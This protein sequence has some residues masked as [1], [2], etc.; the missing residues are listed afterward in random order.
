[1]SKSKSATFRCPDE[2]WEKMEPLIPVRANTHR[3]G[4]GRPRVPDRQCMDGIFFVL[5]TGCA[6]KAL[7]E[8]KICSASTAHARFEEWV[9]AGVFLEFWKAG[10]MEYD[11]W[12]GID[13]QWLSM[14]GAMTK[15][16]L[17]GEK[18][19]S[20]PDRP[21]KDG[22]QAQPVEPSCGCAVGSG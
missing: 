17:A 16:P 2:L 13:W 19:G 18:S 22:R 14:D 9:Q 12:K 20:Q 4:G 8:T 7:D 3:F 11:E 6:W 10:L 5:R 15:A 1:M 21:G